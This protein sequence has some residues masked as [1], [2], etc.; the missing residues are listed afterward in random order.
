MKISKNQ[1]DKIAINCP[2][3]SKNLSTV[4]TSGNKVK[5]FHTCRALDMVPGKID[6]DRCGMKNCAIKYWIDALEHIDDDTRLF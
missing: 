5:K 4:Y 1:F 6:W 2:F 3:R